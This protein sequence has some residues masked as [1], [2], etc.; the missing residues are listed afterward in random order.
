MLLCVELG[1]AGAGDGDGGRT[2]VLPGR[3]GGDGA[4]WQARLWGCQVCTSYSGRKQNKTKKT[5][6]KKITN[7]DVKQE[8]GG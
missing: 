6:R 1:R 5:Q 7:V 3:A 8:E 4:R 2:V